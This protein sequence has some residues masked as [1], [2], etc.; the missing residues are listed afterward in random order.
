MSYA[1]VYH[2]R[3]TVLLARAEWN[4]PLSN[5]DSHAIFS[6]PMSL[7]QHAISIVPTLA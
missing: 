6:P 1:V 3:C 2:P 7:F 5:A 4:V